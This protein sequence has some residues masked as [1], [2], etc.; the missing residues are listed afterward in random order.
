[1]NAH[2]TETNRHAVAGALPAIP[3]VSAAPKTRKKREAKPDTA[4]DFFLKSQREWFD[5]CKRIRPAIDA[6][7][8]ASPKGIEAI[9]AA[10]N[11]KRIEL[12]LGEITVTSLN[13]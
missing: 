5:E 7:G 2:T 13:Q 8:A 3:T 9:T 6:I 12:K 1:M 4:G 11:A 10:L